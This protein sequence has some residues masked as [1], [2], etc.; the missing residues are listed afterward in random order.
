MSPDSLRPSALRLA[1]LIQQH[2]TEIERRWLDRVE[3]DVASSAAPVEPTHLRDG[4]PDYLDALVAQF[5]KSGPQRYGET[6]EPAWS[7]VA[8]E[9]GV[10]RVRIGF[11]ISQLV[12]EFVVLRQTI[13][14]LVAENQIDFAGVE[15][16]LADT[17]D[18][19]ISVSV[20]AYVDARD[21][22]ARKRQAENVAFLTHEMRNPLSSAMLSA[23]EVRRHAVPE[24]LRHLDALDRS[25]Q[26]LN[27]LIDGVLLAEK[28]ASRN[29]EPH[30]ADVKLRDIV[31]PALE[32]ARGAAAKKGIAFD[33]HYD[34]D[35]SVR[36][37]PQ[38]TRSAIQNLVDNAAKYT[39]VGHVDVS[40]DP[41]PNELDVHVRDTCGGISEEELRIIF[42]PFERGTT[43]K[44]GTGLGLAIAK[45]SVEAQGGSIHAE[46]P[47]ASGC[48][49]WFRLPY[50]V[51]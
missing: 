7:K 11:D 33:V 42:E 41:A 1:D 39:D 51:T 15:A 43:G 23:S 49:F 29:I 32:S 35:L 24:Q 25:H 27:S 6:T 5:R 16:I 21:Y 40:V 50:R 48:H 20:A 22:E 19:A 36:L 30:P 45:R 12:H 46:S 18:A 37:D 34:P 3:R 8:R 28:L 13:R 31:E 14:E 47:G 4:L 44:S 9:H 17:L 10:T 38:L 26:R 2:R